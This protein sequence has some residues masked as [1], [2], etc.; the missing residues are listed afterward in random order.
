M[1]DTLALRPVTGP[2][3]AFI[4]A[5]LRLDPVPLL[6]GIRLYS[7]HPGSGLGRLPRAGDDVPPYWAWR[8]AGGL[9][10]ARYFLDRPDRVAGLRV[11]DLGAGCGVVGIAAL[12]AGAASVLAAETDAN[13]RA[14]LRLNARANGVELA[15]TGDDLLDGPPPADVDL[16]SVGDLF[17]DVEVA[18][19]AAAFLERCAAAGLAVLVGDPGRRPLPRERLDLVATYAVPDFGDRLDHAGEGLVFA[20]RTSAGCEQGECQR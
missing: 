10:L 3:E 19:R 4:A 15:V 8:W 20:W 12:K 16:V 7:A 11:L 18:R 6:S 17:Y 1:S 14:A 9:A 5:N 2:I 13:G